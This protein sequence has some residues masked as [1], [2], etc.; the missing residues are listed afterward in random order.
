M[1]L[2]VVT[3]LHSHIDDIEPL[4]VSSLNFEAQKCVGTQS[5]LLGTSGFQAVKRL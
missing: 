1:I 5:Q 2:G 3:R 4:Q